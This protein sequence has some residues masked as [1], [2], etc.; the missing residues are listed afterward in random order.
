MEARL[1]IGLDRKQL[2]AAAFAQLEEEGLDKL[3]MRR[4]A[5]RL[6]VQA[7]A[8][9]WHIGDKA[10]LLG[11]MAAEIYF[12]AD[13]QVPPAV[14]WRTWLASFGRSLR[15]TYAAHRDGALLCARAKPRPRIDRTASAERIAAPLVAFGLDPARAITLRAS[16]I[17]FTMG[18]AVIEANG[19]LHE[20]LGHMYDFDA[21]FE[22]GLDALVAGLDA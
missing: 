18:W 6:N 16:V 5:A 7:S 15:A 12:A 22:N 20:Y 4:L 10:E 3:S 14:D 9:Y 1:E 13:R 17:A 11:L 2:V 21:T 8:L 19:P